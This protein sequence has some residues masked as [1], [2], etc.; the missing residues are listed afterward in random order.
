[1][2]YIIIF[3]L[4]L[5]ANFCFAQNAPKPVDPCQ[6]LDT[7]NIKD[8]LLGTWIDQGDTSHHIYFSP[9]SLVE[10]IKTM[11]DGKFKIDISYWSYKFVDNLFSTDAVT[12][13]S[14]RESKEGY[15][16]HTDVGINYIDAHYMLMG[17]GGKAVFKKK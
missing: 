5:S 3:A 12:C 2:K 8:L 7:N 16:H 17:S 11:V 13:Y 10:T 6:K 9:D 4:F 15:A 14:L 1:M